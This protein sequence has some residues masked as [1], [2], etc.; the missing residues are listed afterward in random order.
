MRICRFRTPNNEENYGVVS[1]EN[2]IYKIE[3]DI[4]SDF[5]QT[6]NTYNLNNVQL[7]APFIPKQMF[8][9]GLNFLDHLQMANE[10]LGTN[11]TTIEQPDPWFKSITS[12]IGE[13]DN[14][15]IP[16]DSPSGI[17]YEGECIAVIGKTTRRADIDTAWN[18][19]LGYTCGNDISERTWQRDDR[20]FW[21]AKGSDTF[22][23]LGPWI[24]TSFN[25]REKNGMIV[26]LN[27]KEVQ[28]AYTSDMFF[29]FGKLISFISQA[30]TLSPGDMI[31]SG[32][33]GH[34]ENMEHG[35]IVEV[36]VE[37]I[38]ILTN[39]IVNE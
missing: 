10:A 36:E 39:K 26:R 35:D 24:E 37:N 7:L 4:F 38:G 5:Q 32:T 1:K 27:G 12:I 16:N 17:Q 21:R 30:I 31:W 15:I 13:G 8:G 14:V 23:P 18:N 28:K 22:A 6:A 2:I 19:I 33:S 3:G 11:A 34:P 20:E 25:P 9:P 29:D